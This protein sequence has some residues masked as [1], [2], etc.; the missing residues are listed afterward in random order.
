MTFYEMEVDMWYKN[1][2]SILSALILSSLSI[3]SVLFL[4]LIAK[5]RRGLDEINQTLP[6]CSWHAVDTK[7]TRYRNVFS[8][9]QQFPSCASNICAFFNAVPRLLLPSRRRIRCARVNPRRH[10]KKGKR[11]RS[12]RS[13]R[14]IFFFAFRS[15]GIFLFLD[16][17]PR[18]RRK[19]T[20]SL[21]I[22]FANTHELMTR[23]DKHA[24]SLFVEKIYASLINIYIV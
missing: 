15:R 1:L 21:S 17:A 10:P 4:N 12:L 22:L 23:C 3:S 6:V 11:N 7:E 5:K 18:E 20:N 13:K 16:I 2:F 9:F 14:A 8:S 19:E 24:L